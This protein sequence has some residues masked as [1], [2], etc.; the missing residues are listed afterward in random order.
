MAERMEM[1]LRRGTLMVCLAGYAIS[2][3]LKLLVG[4]LELRAKGKGAI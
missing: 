2:A 3:S 1:L 4:G